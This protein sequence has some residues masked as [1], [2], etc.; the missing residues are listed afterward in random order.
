MAAI[1]FGIIVLQPFRDR[2]EFCLRLLPRDARFEKSVT[3]NPARA[4]VLEF[5]ARV[6]ERLLHRRRHP[7]VERVA[8]E[9]TVEFFRRDADDSVLNTV[10]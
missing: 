8:D 1:R 3:F 9:G 4:P 10:H 6:I 2:G 7:E 5:I